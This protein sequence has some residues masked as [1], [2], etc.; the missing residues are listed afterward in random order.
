MTQI[1]NGNRSLIQ[2]SDLIHIMVRFWPYPEKYWKIKFSTNGLNILN[3]HLKLYMYAKFSCL[4]AWIS[5][6]FIK[7]IPK[8]ICDRFDGKTSSKMGKSVNFFDPGNHTV[9][10]T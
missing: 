1:H 8:N 9:Y 3:L 10:V 7:N 5:A 2:A 4:N 6:Y